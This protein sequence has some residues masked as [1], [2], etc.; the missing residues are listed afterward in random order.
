M[1][2]S[3]R[4]GRIFGI[5][6]GFN[7]SLLVVFWLITWSLAAARF[8]VQIPGYSNSEYWIVAALTGFLFFASLLLHEIS[9]AVVARR[10]GVQ[11]DG[12]TL[13]LFGG[14]ARF[15]GEAMTA[16]SEFRIAAV[17]PATSIVL[18]SVA[19]GTSLA[20][21]AIG[22]SPLI[23]GAV[24]WLGF[25]NIVLAIF[26]LIPGFPL[27]GGRV[28]RAWIWGKRGDRVSATR[29]AARGGRIFAFLLIALGIAEFAYA[30]SLGGIW[31]VFLGWF[32]LGAA[33]AEEMQTLVRAA[34]RD[35][36]VDDIMSSDPVTVP[37]D[38]SVADFIDL[39]ALRHRFSSFPVVDAEGLPTGIVT[40]SHVKQVDAEDRER[41]S[42]GDIFCA[43]DDVATASPDEPV[44]A[45]LERLDG[46]SEG[47]ALIMSNDHLS[48]IVS[49]RDIQRALLGRGMREEIPGLPV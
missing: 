36:R 35:I 19:L 23:V 21:D 28:L 26:N 20:I 34:L 7:W 17:G 6:V 40:L 27:D 22:V 14:V 43:L 11:V 49:P 12:I 30:A 47:R 29:T 37:Q 8:P 45:I 46:C 1:G 18:G 38:T 42:V 44:S 32:L 4:I 33:Q 41:R 16:R 13:W 9:H 48:G 31:F 3:V 39:Y 15:R 25:I 24:G 10:S 2:E 5:D